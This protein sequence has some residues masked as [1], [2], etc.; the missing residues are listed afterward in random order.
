M[1]ILVAT[2][3]SKPIH[4]GMIDSLF[5]SQTEVKKTW[6]R[7]PGFAVD[8]GREKLAQMAID[9]GYKKLLFADSDAGWD[10]N[11]MQRLYE[12]DL[13]IVCGSM[14]TAELP[15]KP[16]MAH[17][18][19]IAD[20][21]LYLYNSAD[22]MEMISKYIRV[23]GIKEDVPNRITFDQQPDD[24]VEID[25]CGMHFTMIDVEVLKAIS[26]PRFVMG[27]KTG[28]GEDFY[29]CIKAQ[30]AGF[31]IYW[32]KSVH[33]EHILTERDQGVGLREFLIFDQIFSAYDKMAWL[34]KVGKTRIGAK[35]KNYQPPGS[36]QA[37]EIA[38][39]VENKE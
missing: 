14:Y 5:Y 8:E 10:E 33:T 32:D 19:G 12:R 25:G 7:L 13:P 20:D 38:E 36:V 26:P 6:Q 2:P 27:G 22:V 28:A 1:S 30:E 18:Q 17:F 16:T 35:D 39:V 37:V 21:G 3:Y 11:A 9:G 15:P 29:F 4:G 24:I 23:H 34:I 31:K